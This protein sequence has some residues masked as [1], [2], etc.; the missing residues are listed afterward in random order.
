[1]VLRISLVVGLPMV[2][3]TL[4]ILVMAEAAEVVGTVKAREATVVVTTVAGG[5]GGGHGG[6]LELATTVLRGKGPRAVGA[7]S[8]EK[9]SRI[10]GRRIS[11][12]TQKGNRSCVQKWF[13]LDLKQGC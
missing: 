13:K 4:A 11:T 5:I 6:G 3:L 2:L 12:I 8:G 10:A 1:M 9:R 7:Q